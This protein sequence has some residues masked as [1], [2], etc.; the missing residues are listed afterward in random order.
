MMNAT[1]SWRQRIREEN[2]RLGIRPSPRVAFVEEEQTAPQASAPKEARPRH[3]AGKMNGLEKRYAAYLDIRKAVGEIRGW[4][5]EAIK[6]RLAPATFYNVDFTVH[7][8]DGSFEHHE[9]KGGHWEDDARVKI[10]VAARIF[11]EYKFVV[12]RE[13]DRQRSEWVFEELPN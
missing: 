10:K 6:L 12:A 11:P 8:A 2:E 3:E 13:K 9:V 5:F 4:K 7:M 1:V